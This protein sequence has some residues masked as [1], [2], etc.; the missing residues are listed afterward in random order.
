MW[1]DRLAHWASLFI[2]HL[3]SQPPRYVVPPREGGQTPL[4]YREWDPLV[5]RF[6]TDKGVDYPTFQ[7]VRRLLEAHL[8]RLSDARPASW[9]NRDAQLAFYL[10]AFNA[11]T[12]HQVLLHY[13]ISSI[14][15]V[16]V[17]FARPYPVGP[18]NLTLHQ[19]LHAKIR[20]F[21]DPRVHA[22]VVPAARGGPTLRAY[23]TAGLQQELDE[24]MKSYLRS[25]TTA[26]V[27]GS[28][29]YLTLPAVVR[30]YAQDFA[31]HGEPHTLTGFIRSQLNPATTLPYLAPFLP[32]DIRTALHGRRLIL[33]FRTYDWILN[34]R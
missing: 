33:A 21:G 1:T 30:W 24:Q 16:G 9:D 4:Q 15:D 2:A 20:T 3:E 25:T 29:V 17:A 26:N 10:N 31:V 27:Q 23:T 32:D 12:I 8:D 22:A 11:I 18:E 5:K 14:R 34:Q 28:V 7:R 19:V 6:A 13:P